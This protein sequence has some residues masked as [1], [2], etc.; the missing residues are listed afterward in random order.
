MRRDCMHG[1][2][3]LLG[4][5]RELIGSRNWVVIEFYLCKNMRFFSRLFQLFLLLVIWFFWMNAWIVLDSR[6]EVQRT[7]GSYDWYTVWL[8]LWASVRSDG[9]LSPV[10]QQRVDAAISVYNAW[11]IQKI[12]V[13]WYD[14]DETYLEAMSMGEYM[15]SKSVREE[16]LVIDSWWYDTLASVQR[17][18]NEFGVEKMIIFTQRYH[19]WRSVFLAKHSDVDAVWYS[20]DHHAYSVSDLWTLREMFARVKAFI[21]V[22]LL[23]SEEISWQSLL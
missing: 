16:D 18:K 17:A 21:E 13:S 1:R 14:K 19:L 5:Y 22:M 11:K 8:V 2:L 12:I 20:T 7:P 3:K 9:S 6:N 15:L 23:R 10:L 4:V